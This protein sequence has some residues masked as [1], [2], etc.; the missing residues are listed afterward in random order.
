MRRE[1]KRIRKSLVLALALAVITPVAANAKTTVM[2][3]PYTNLKST[4]Q[5]VHLALS[6]YP[7]TSGLYVQQ[8]VQ[9]ADTSR[10]SLC[11][12]AAQ[13]WISTSQGASFAPN[14]DIQF[15]PTATF[16]SGTTAVDCTKSICGIFI[17]LDHTAPTD[18]SEDQFI[19]LSFAADAT[20][21]LP[22]DVIT[23]TVNDKALSAAQPLSVNYR[24]VFKVV[25]TAKSGVAVTYAS[26]APACAINGNEVTVL[27]G[28]GYCDIA[29]TSA[30]NAQYSGV[31][32]HFP[33]QLN[34]GTQSVSVSTS[35][36]AG[37]KLNLPA[38]SNFGEKVTYSVSK[39]ANCSLS[40]NVLSLKKKGAC[41][42]KASAPELKDTYAAL[43]Q[44]I[45]VK[46]K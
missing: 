34:V 46:I 7:A 30:G 45:S 32:A 16:T 23:A 11:N 17:R 35:V 38:T 6:G 12:Q 9:S 40:G 44:T 37:T 2:G 1:M 19:P 25:A 36:K 39:S 26:L 14:A 4:G 10:P 33:L 13:L 3:G 29:V 24:D 8:C 18:L 21:A 27:K 31:T 20:P 22:A 41:A 15:K 28:T 5:V 42:V 43:K